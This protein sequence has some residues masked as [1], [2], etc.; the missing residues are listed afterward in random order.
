VNSKKTLF[1]SYENKN[2]LT[3]IIGDYCKNNSYEK[4]LPK[5]FQLKSI[6]KKKFDALPQIHQ[7]IILDKFHNLQETNS[8][9]RI[10][11][12]IKK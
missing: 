9:E 5:L 8:I 10:E 3:T 7:S 1:C 12:L 6:N 4:N 2:L 11:S